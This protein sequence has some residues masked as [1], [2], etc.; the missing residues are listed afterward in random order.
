VL[1]KRSVRRPLSTS[2]RPFG[3]LAMTLLPVRGGRGMRATKIR[4]VMVV[5]PI[6]VGVPA[7]AGTTS[8][9][10]KIGA[11]LLLCKMSRGQQR[12][13]RQQRWI[14]SQKRKRRLMQ[15]LMSKKMTVKVRV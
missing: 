2:N 6:A 3:L 14:C 9:T 11:G 15:K 13:C 5:V 12:W 1:L 10:A 8:V 4:L 7:A